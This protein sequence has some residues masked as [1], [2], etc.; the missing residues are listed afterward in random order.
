MVCNKPGCG[1]ILTRRN[2]IR[3]HIRWHDGNE[4]NVCKWSDCGMALDTKYG[5]ERHMLI[6]TG[7]KPFECGVGKKCFNHNGSCKQHM[8]IRIREVSFIEERG[9]RI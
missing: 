9:G 6:H 3:T 5:L 4:K 1:K 7:E 8:K 2:Q